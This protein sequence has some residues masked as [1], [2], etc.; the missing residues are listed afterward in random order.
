MPR[1]SGQDPISYPSI[2]PATFAENG[3][4]RIN[5]SPPERPFAAVRE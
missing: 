2:F 3:V 5:E 4:I 1:S